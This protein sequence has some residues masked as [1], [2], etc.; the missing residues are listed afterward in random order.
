MKIAISSIDCSKEIELAVN[1]KKEGYDVHIFTPSLF[2]YRMTEGIEG[3]LVH[4]V[5][6]VPNRYSDL[7]TENAT[8]LINEIGGFEELYQLKTI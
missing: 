2:G 3:I 4:R 7:Y 6:S 1:L 8:K 5:E